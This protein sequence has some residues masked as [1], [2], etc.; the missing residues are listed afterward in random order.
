MSAQCENGSRK[1]DL[2]T[3]PVASLAALRSDNRFVRELTADP[4]YLLRNDRAH[5]AI[6]KAEEGDLSLVNE[7]LEVL[8]WPY[9]EQPV[10]EKFAEKRPEWTRHRA[11]YSM[12]SCSS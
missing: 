2:A 11:E 1:T 9:D 6:D 12:L 5:L 8:G 10:K 3:P 7:Q 4:K